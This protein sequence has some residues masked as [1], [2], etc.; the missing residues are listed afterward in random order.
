MRMTW[1][2]VEVKKKNKIIY[3]FQENVKC[4]LFLIE[5]QPD[6][7]NM[8]EAK[9]I[10]NSRLRYLAWGLDLLTR[11]QWQPVSNVRQIS[12]SNNDINISV[13]NRKNKFDADYISGIEMEISM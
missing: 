3:T 10:R 2:N 9:Q 13:S 5:M 1:A 6:E 7:C 4:R 12:T 11:L 8:K